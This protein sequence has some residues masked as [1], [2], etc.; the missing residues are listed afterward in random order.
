M[1]T[2]EEKKRK[3]ALSLAM[4]G[5]TS[6]LR[7]NFAEAIEHFSEAI[8]I[9][10][11]YSWALAHRGVARRDHTE[12]APPEAQRDLVAAIKK[13]P[14]EEVCVVIDPG[15]LRKQKLP[16][17]PWAWA[18]LGALYYQ[19]NQFE[20]AEE[21][22]QEAL[23]Q[24]PKYPWALAHYGQTL[25]RLAGEVPGESKRIYLKAEDKLKKALD[26]TGDNY[27]FAHAMIAA[28]YGRLAA[29]IL[30][31]QEENSQKRQEMAQEKAQYYQYALD[32]ILIAV[33]Q[34]KTV[35]DHIPK[36]HGWTRISVSYETNDLEA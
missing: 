6:R 8:E 21:C 32:E 5:E 13:I 28:V 14:V 20:Y 7:K 9:Y 2:D 19:N 26:L 29:M 27:A 16:P 25:F 12:T 22:Y 35:F 30:D 18:N 4:R 24:N 15:K 34:D 11:N 3:Q 10:P 31:Y 36:Q 23:E 17:Y 33:Q 1:S